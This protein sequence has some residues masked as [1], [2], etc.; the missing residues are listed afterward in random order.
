MSVSEACR[1]TTLSAELDDAVEYEG[2][3]SNTMYANT[4]QATAN[5]EAVH[6]VG[7]VMRSPINWYWKTALAHPPL[8]RVSIARRRV[9]DDPPVGATV[10]LPHVEVLAAFLDDL[11]VGTGQR[12]RDPA[13]LVGQVPGMFDPLRLHRHPYDAFV[14]EPLAQDPRWAA[15]PRS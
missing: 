14:G 8:A 2:R 7:N 3:R 1:Y 9:G 10:L 4:D 11:I 6:C 5:H 15:V 13:E 12:H